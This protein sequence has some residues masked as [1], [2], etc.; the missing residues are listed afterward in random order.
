MSK[1]KNNSSDIHTVPLLIIFLP[2]V[3]FVVIFSG[4]FELLFF[5]LFDML[6]Q[7]Y[8]EKSSFLAVDLQCSLQDVFSLTVIFITMP[9]K[10]LWIWSFV[11]EPN[12]RDRWDAIKDRMPCLGGS[13]FLLPHMMALLDLRGPQNF[14]WKRALIANKGTKFSCWTPVERPFIQYLMLHGFIQNTLGYIKLQKSL[15]PV[16]YVDLLPCQI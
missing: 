1:C 6:V 13:F 12:N 9:T 3:L 4:I 15:R 8:K 7:P 10:S 5:F 2:L 16:S 11:W 14:C